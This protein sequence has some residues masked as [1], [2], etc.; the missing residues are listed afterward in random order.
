M[1]LTLGGVFEARGLN[2]GVVT[3][4]VMLRVTGVDETA[5]ERGAG[6]GDTGCHGAVGALHAGLPDVSPAPS[7]LD[8][9]LEKQA[10]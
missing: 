9:R 3:V 7:C 6:G 5:E 8:L 10:S 1:S 4:R 2:V